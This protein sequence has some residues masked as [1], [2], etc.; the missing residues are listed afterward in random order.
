LTAY[1]LFHAL[2]AGSPKVVSCD[3]ATQSRSKT[4]GFGC[5]TW[6]SLAR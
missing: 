2:L 1:L 6:D 5:A 3:G 4:S